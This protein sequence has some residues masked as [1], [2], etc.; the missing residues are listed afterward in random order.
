MTNTGPNPSVQEP[1]W[2]TEV[3]DKCSFSVINLG[4]RFF[5]TTDSGVIPALIP[6]TR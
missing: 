1:A 4:S 6:L 3:Q 2:K 5:R